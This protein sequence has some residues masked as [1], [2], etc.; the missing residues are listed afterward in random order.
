MT[1][2][3]NTLTVLSSL[4]LALIAG[5]AN[6]APV[7]MSAEWAA[8]ACEAFNKNAKL[9]D[10]LGGKWIANNKGRGFKVIHMYRSDCEDSPLIE[11]R[12]SE[13]DGKAFCSYGGK[14][15]TAKLDSGAD[16][17]MYAT[18]SKWH[19]M[20]AGEYGPM[21]A[22]MFGRLQFEGP[23]MEAMSVMTP[24]EQFLLLAGKVPSTEASCPK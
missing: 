18:T 7:L 5:A 4:T 21:K 15:E 8:Q 3:L 14:V 9:T 22:M 10:G 17:L 23:K 19:D 1:K 6:A 24:F 20:G 12:I 2:Q 11:M 16:Y 13:K